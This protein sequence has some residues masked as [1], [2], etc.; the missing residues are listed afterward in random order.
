MRMPTSV[1]AFTLTFGLMMHGGALVLPAQPSAVAPGARI[2]FELLNGERHEGQ[3]IA[4]RPEA[5][6]VSFPTNGTTGT[7]RLAQIAQLDVSR[8]QHR[9]VLRSATIGLIAGG[10]AG[11]IIGGM[12]CKRSDC[13]FERQS[14][15]VWAGALILG[16]PGLVVGG[17]VGLLPRERWQRVYLDGNAVRV[18]MRALPGRGAGMELALAF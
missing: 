14:D 3:V 10:S 17:L 8:G 6:D 18:N 15:G 1:L 12:T 16:A 4:L 9:R 5:L 11:A 2:R 13:L 7:Y